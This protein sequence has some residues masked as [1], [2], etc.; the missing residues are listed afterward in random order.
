[1]RNPPQKKKKKEIRGIKRRGQGE[2]MHLLTHTLAVRL[3][4]ALADIYFCFQRFVLLAL[5]CSQYSIDVT[6]NILSKFS[7]STKWGR[8]KF[9][10]KE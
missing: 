3:S 4:H 7:F 8:N 1:M 9:K 10:E 5:K 6:Y 2:A